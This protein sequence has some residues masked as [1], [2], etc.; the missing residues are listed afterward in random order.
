MRPRC[1]SGAAVSLKDDTLKEGNGL[2]DA[3]PVFAT[4]EAELRVL[5]EFLDEPKLWLLDAPA[6]ECDPPEE[7]LCEAP[8]LDDP[9]ELAGLPELDACSA[10]TGD[11]TNKR[12]AMTRAESRIKHLQTDLDVSAK[13]LSFYL[14]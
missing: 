12:K 14:L 5:A 13:S 3:M 6:D 7:L 10:R 1:F 11:E 8:E 4:C 2:K 9:L